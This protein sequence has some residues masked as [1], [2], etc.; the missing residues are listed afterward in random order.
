M[1]SIWHALEVILRTTLANFTIL[2]GFEFEK[3]KILVNWRLWDIKNK[4]KLRREKK[5]K[6]KI[7]LKKRGTKRERD[8]QRE[9]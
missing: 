6:E 1:I 9:R 4:N 3:D 2:Q 7:K 8:I 5:E